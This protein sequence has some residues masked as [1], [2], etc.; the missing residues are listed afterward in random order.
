MKTYNDKINIDLIS[1]GVRQKGK[2]AEQKTVVTFRENAKDR[3]AFWLS[4][5]MDQL[6]FLT[7][8]GVPYTLNNDGSTR[9]SSAYSSL[10][11]AADVVAPSAKRH[12]R[13]D[14]V[15]STLVAGNTAGMLATDT[16]TYKAIVDTV[17]YAK[18]HYI[19][20]LMSGGKEY[21]VAFIRPEGLAQLKKDAD[22]QR[23]VVTGA[24]RGKTNPFFEGGIMTI[25]GLVFFE[26]RLVY[27]TKGAASGSKWGAGG[28]IDGSRMLVCGSQALGF[29]DLGAPEWSEKWFNYDSSPGVNIDKMF[30]FLKPQFYSIYDKTVEDFG[31]LA[32]D[33]AIA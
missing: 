29:A 21:Y 11:F 1:H 22:Y 16:L 9:N 4:N 7:L 24:D 23:A 31:V 26:H 20:P 6:A 17:V 14:G 27:N 30:G 19:K 32:I 10:V 5:R 8:S 15:N 13:W 33:H 28:T 2:L 3:L 25:D 18:T 12:R